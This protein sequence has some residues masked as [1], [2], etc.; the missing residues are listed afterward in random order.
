MSQEE[1]FDV[2][3]KKIVD[4]I[5]TENYIIKMHAF[6]LTYGSWPCSGEKRKQIDQSLE[7]M[8]SRRRHLRDRRRRVL[9]MVECSG[10]GTTTS[11]P[12]ENQ[13]HDKC[14]PKCQRRDLR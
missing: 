8:M 12:G 6:N 7:V 13:W 5:D 4:Q 1:T 10:C 14:C 9:D 11:K 3:V 2:R